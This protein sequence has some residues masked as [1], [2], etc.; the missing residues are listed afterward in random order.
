MSQLKHAVLLIG[1]PKP[2][3]ST[4][5]SLGAGFVAPLEAAGVTVETFHAHRVNRTEN[6]TA[7]FIE[8]LNR[9]DLFVVAFPL[10]VDT[11][12]YVTLRVFEAVAA[13]RALSPS[14]RE[15]RIV[16]IANCGFPEAH[17]NEYALQVCEQFAA[18]TG[19][20]WAGGI[21]IGQGGAISGTPLP[22]IAGRAHHIVSGF[23]SA[24]A[25]LLDGGTVPDDVV[26][27]ISRPIIPHKV[28]TGMG[29]VG[30]MVQ[31]NGQQGV[32]SLWRKPYEVSDA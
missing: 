13:H 6:A 9:T 32:R 5:A 18:E 20:A 1:S 28:Y 19:F 12:P 27:Q 15:Q 10:Y 21:P 22:E 25:A 2:K 4:S 31:A 30:W 7:A 17:H 16:C 3:A 14:E 24:A 26:A 8:T 29:T 23:A 11:L